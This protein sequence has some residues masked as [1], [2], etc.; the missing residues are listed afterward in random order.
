MNDI[1]KKQKNKIKTN[2]MYEKNKL[3][4]YELQN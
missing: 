4:Y 1:C 2:A 3:N